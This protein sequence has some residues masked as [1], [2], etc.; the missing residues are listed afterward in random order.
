MFLNGPFVEYSIHLLLFG[1]PLL[2]LGYF[3][4]HLSWFL[5]LLFGFFF[6]CWFKGLKIMFDGL[7]LFLEYGCNKKLQQFYNIPKLVF[8]IV[9]KK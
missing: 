3:C 5:L 1:L 4:Y 2:L 7:S 9:K 6:F 8:H